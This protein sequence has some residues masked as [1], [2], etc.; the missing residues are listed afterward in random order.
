MMPVG[1]ALTKAQCDVELER[2]NY[3]E[4]PL[5]KNDYGMPFGQA[6]HVCKDRLVVLTEHGIFRIHHLTW[7]ESL[8]DPHGQVLLSWIET[9]AK[10]LEIY[11]GKVK[12]FKGVVDD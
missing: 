5:L 1:T 8:L 10:A 2:R 4:H 3:L 7:E 11:L 12:G 6:I 9:F